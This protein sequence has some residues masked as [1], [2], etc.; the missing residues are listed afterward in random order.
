MNECDER[1]VIG[2]GGG[3]GGGRGGR[4]SFLFLVGEGGQIEHY[5]YAL[6]CCAL[7]GE[8]EVSTI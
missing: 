5:Y 1:S 2:L 7:M 3:V 8:V 4:R 6:L